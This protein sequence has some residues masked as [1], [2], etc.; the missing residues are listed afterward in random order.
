MI[1]PSK[2]D[3][4]STQL[5][6]RLLSSPYDAQ[7]NWHVITGGPCSG[8]STLVNL[9]A[10]RGFSTVMES[11]RLY[12]Q[13]EMSNGHTDHGIRTDPAALQRAIH[14]LQLG[15]E[16]GLRIEDTLFL[17]SAVPGCLAWFR[18][19]GLDPNEILPSCFRRRYASV[20]ILA[21]LPFHVDDQRIDEVAAIAG[22]LDRW[23]TQDYLDLGYRVVRVPVLPPEERLAFVLD[24]LAERGLA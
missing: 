23:H 2:P 1:H 18:A 10:E 11:A 15:V 13:K 3:H 22:F 12:I 14:R 16:A 20:F 21:P 8:K 24:R 19:F 4:R 9:L 6:P 5:D 7:T 17:D